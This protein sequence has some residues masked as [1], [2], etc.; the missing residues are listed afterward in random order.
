MPKRLFESLK[1]RSPPKLKKGYAVK[2]KRKKTL[3]EKHT[4]PKSRKCV[5]AEKQGVTAEKPHAS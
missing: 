1:S 5:P 3:V 4:H 2:K